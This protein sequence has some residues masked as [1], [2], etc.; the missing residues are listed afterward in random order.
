[1][2]SGDL[3]ARRY[4]LRDILGSGGMAHAWRAVDEET[5]RLVVV[6]T[7]RLD[8]EIHETQDALRDRRERLGRFSREAELLAQ[9]R[10]P[11]IPEAYAQDK[12]DGRPFLVMQFINGQTLHDFLNEHWP[13]PTAAAV[14]IAYQVTEAL[15]AAH[16]CDVVHR[17]LKPHN[18]LL[19]HG[20]RVFLIDF[21][22]AKPLW[23]DATRYTAT[24]ASVGTDGYKAPEQLLERDITPATDLYVLGCV[25]YRLLTGRPPFVRERSGRGIVDQH[26]NDA[27]VPPSVH[28]AVPG[29]LERLVLRL[30]AKDPRDRPADTAEV[31]AM[32]DPHLPH[33]GDP[34]P[35]PALTPDPTLLF[36]TPGAVRASDAPSVQPS[37]IR[38]APPRRS[39]SH[40]FLSR[41]GASARLEQAKEDLRAGNPELARRALEELLR[42][43]VRSFGEPDI[44]IDRIRLALADSLRL[45][46]ECEQAAERYAE[47]AGDRGLP[48]DEND[49]RTAIVL[50][51]RLGEAEC[52][53]AVGQV[54]DGG[55]AVLRACVPLVA[56]LPRRLIA[57]VVER[58]QEL[59]VQLMELGYDVEA[60]RRL[61]D[62]LPTSPDVI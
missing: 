52:L 31:L 62:E 33:L 11:G 25:L 15:G 37:P 5:G 24:G 44:L 28:V 10:H 26:I 14:A 59:G 12:H 57:E 50:C 61:L 4:R 16:M 29:N 36:R 48:P 6:K 8:I 20:G 3:V 22:I 2:K 17:D 54:E 32:L 13:L 23:S 9:V 18:I 35:E 46:G 42:G 55:L 53:A 1:M 30:L 45:I 38:P 34:T 60:A 47:L 56:R 49:E 21:G 51:A 58:C 7:P 40:R 39:R 27:P 43:A 41:P 19:A